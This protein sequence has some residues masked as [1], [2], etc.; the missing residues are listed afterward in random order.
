MRQTHESNTRKIL[1]EIASTDENPIGNVLSPTI[2]KQC[3]HPSSDTNVNVSKEIPIID[4]NVSRTSRI[5]QES[6]TSNIF[7]IKKMYKQLEARTLPDGWSKVLLKNGLMVGYW[8][9]SVDP[10]KKQFY[11]HKDES[12]E[13]FINGH[14]TSVPGLKPGTT[15]NNIL[16][17]IE[18]FQ[19]LLLCDGTG[20]KDS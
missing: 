9:S 16:K 6:E 10:P 14:S 20:L 12:V 17:N 5:S 4:Q 11:I 18:L 3:I 15:V 19:N 7:T 1:L 2:K 8:G 13:V